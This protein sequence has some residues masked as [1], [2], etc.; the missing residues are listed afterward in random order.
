MSRTLL[1][2]AL[3]FTACRAPSPLPKA[4]PF[5]F[6]AKASPA[7]SDFNSDANIL[8]Q[9]NDVGAD[10][11][12]DYWNSGE[13]G[14]F[15]G[16]D[17]VDIAYRIHRA[18]NPKAAVVILPGR[19]EA[20]V[21]FAEVSRD[22]VKQGYSTYCLTLRGQ[23]EA[24][25]MLTDTDKGYVA[26]FD[27]YV[28]DT[29]QFISTI[30]KNDGLPVFML[31][32]SLG[33]AV[34]VLVVDEHPDDVA[35][36]ALSSP[37]LEIDPGSFPPIVV[38]SLAGGICDS[39]DGSGYAIG[40]GPYSEEKNFEKN[41]V[42]HSLP[43]WTWKVQ[44]LN[45]DKSI[46]LGGI[47]WRW[48]CQA[49][50]ASSRAQGVG[51]FSS[52][53]TVLFQAGADTIVKPGGQTKYCADAPRCTLSVMPEAKHEQLQERDDIRNLVLSQTVKLFDSVVNP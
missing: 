29:H 47:T 49:L 16:V 41:S 4:P 53:P 32:H 2:T 12:R 45:D 27:D 26:Y 13:A 14:T 39:T 34:A 24:G 36:L 22:L 10:S 44:Q 8:R 46:R 52:V 35:A 23:G 7:P 40:S 25:R 1:F 17:K 42:T 43:R 48:L 37:M 9:W 33:G 21:K 18:T 51:K 31:A 15:Q 3:V 30:V 11:L 28:T 5:D 6:A 19:T 20:I 38:S 50:V